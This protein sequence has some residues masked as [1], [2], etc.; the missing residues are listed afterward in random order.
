MGFQKFEYNLSWYG[1]LFVYPAYHSLNF[2]DLWLYNI[3]QIWKNFTVSANIFFCPMS[4]WDSHT[5]VLDCLVLSHKPLFYYFLSP[6]FPL[7]ASSWIVPITMSSR[8]VNIV[9]YYLI[10]ILSGEFFISDILFFICIKFIWLSFISMLI[11]YLPSFESLKTLIIVVLKILSVNSTISVSPAHFHV[12]VLFWALS[13]II[14]FL[15]R[16]SKFW[17]GV[18]HCELLHHWV[19]DFVVNI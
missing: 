17:L 19:L 3:H 7:H 9:L 15:H 4:F 2:L 18:V 11:V 14:L 13:H 8:S 1:F 10:L 16:S 12:W 5:H 6:F